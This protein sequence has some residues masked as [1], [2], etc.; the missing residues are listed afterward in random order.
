MKSI[1]KKKHVNMDLEKSC[2][3]HER[4]PTFLLLN[5]NSHS[6]TLFVHTTGP[7]PVKE[8]ALPVKGFTS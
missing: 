8:A 6:D 3:Y 7:L 5:D 1:I 2:S 4:Y